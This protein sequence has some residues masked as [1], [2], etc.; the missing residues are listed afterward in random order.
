[1]PLLVPEVNPEHCGLIAYQRKNHNYTSG[2]IATNP[3]CSAAGLVV[4]LKPIHDA[5]GIEALNVVTMQAL[6]GAGGYLGRR[7]R[8]TSTDNVIPYIGGEEEKL[9]SE[10]RKILGTICRWNDRS[11]GD[12]H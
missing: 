4:A 11:G 3:N 12:A 8:W 1:M 2:F 10:P 7:C 5:F 9:E 6:S